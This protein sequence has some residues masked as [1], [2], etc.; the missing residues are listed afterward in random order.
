MASTEDIGKG[1]EAEARR[2]R[3]W[4]RCR[5]IA[6][7]LPPETFAAYAPVLDWL[8]EKVEPPVAPV[9]V[10]DERS[11]VAACRLALLAL[12][13]HTDTPAWSSDTL[14]RMTKAVLSIPGAAPADVFKAEWALILEN[15]PALTKTM[16]A[17]L[18]ALALTYLLEHRSRQTELQWLVDA[19]LA[20]TPTEGFFKFQT[21]VLRP[22]L[23]T[24]DVQ[25]EVLFQLRDDPVARPY[26]G[27]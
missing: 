17:F 10:V 19:D 22:E 7:E 5:E 8:G 20:V 18:R 13:A 25:A 21:F 12:D 6:A 24:D 14:T 3:D 27:R 16:A 4:K 23:Y 1:I 2:S 9:A 26:I 15:G 11:R